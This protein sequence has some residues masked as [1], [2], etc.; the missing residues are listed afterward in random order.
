MYQQQHDK[1]SGLRFL[2]SAIFDSPCT[3]CSIHMKVKENTSAQS[4]NELLEIFKR[5]FD[6]FLLM[7]NTKQ[8]TILKKYMSYFALK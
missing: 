2:F 4:Q 1:S 6:V 3:V 5:I 8:K 7:H